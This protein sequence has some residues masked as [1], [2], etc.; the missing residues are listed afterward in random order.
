[1]RASTKPDA[2]RSAALRLFLRSGLRR[3]SMDAIAAEANVTKQ[4]VYRYYGSKE[5]LFVEVLGGMVAGARTDVLEVMPSAPVTRE[6]LEKILLATAQRILDRILDPTYLD[7]ARI[8]IAEARNFPELATMFRAAA[9]E[10]VAGAL[11]ELLQSEHTAA[12]V[13]V[14]DIQPALRLFVGPLLFAELE[15]LLGDPA[16][17]RQR[18][19]ATLPAVIK[20]FVSAVSDPSRQEQGADG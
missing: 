14:R 2:I 9:I 6:Q 18:T 10:G 16:V 12:V 20:L 11:A 19:Q 1:M 13:T 8:Y 3:T 4:T 15:A 17:V 7:L 5:Q